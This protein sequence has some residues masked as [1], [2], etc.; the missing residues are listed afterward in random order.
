MNKFLII[1]REFDSGP[2]YI[3]SFN[4]KNNKKNMFI[5]D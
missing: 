2:F 4:N 3:L 1:L 5:I